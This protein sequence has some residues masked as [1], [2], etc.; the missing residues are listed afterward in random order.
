MELGM[1]HEWLRLF[2]WLGISRM[3]YLVNME[4]VC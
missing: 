4:E 1:K 2:R 3:I